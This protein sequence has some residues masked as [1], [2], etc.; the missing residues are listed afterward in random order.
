M[1]KL[2]PIITILL[3]FAS[4]TTLS[5]ATASSPSIIINGY[6]PGESSIFQIKHENNNLNLTT[7]SLLLDESTNFTDKLN[8]SP[9]EIFLTNS[10][11]STKSYKLKF[12][13]EGFKKI[14]YNSDGSTI[15]SY[16]DILEQIILK[17]NF[18]KSSPSIS[19]TSYYISNGT[20]LQS[21]TGISYVLSLDSGS[22]FDSEKPSFKFYFYWNSAPEENPVPA[23]EYLAT[24]TIE[25]I[26]I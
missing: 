7:G 6:L 26:T 14:I 17:I 23:G 20:D 13:T 4:L 21:S 25:N 11:A 10:T 18:E 5:A 22:N 12:K 8:T 9:F 19:G 24:V 16:G 15:D 1:K 3:A 2:L